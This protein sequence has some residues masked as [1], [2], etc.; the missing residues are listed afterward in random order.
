MAFSQDPRLLLLDEPQA[1]LAR[2]DFTTTPSNLLKQI[3][4]ERNITIAIHRKHDHAC[5]VLIGGT[6]SPCWLKGNAACRKTHPT[7]I[8]KATPRCAR[9]ICWR[10]PKTPPDAEAAGPAPV[11]KH[12]GFARH[13]N[14]NTN[15]ISRNKRQP[16]LYCAR[17]SVGFMGHPPP[18]TAKAYRAGR[19]L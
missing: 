3:K 2:A 16:C 15:P 18:T 19:Q 8:H 9:R 12:L 11:T 4:D 7:T 6:A 10:I 17:L 5:G 1:V 14:M 13:K